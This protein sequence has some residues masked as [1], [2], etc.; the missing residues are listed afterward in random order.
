MVCELM[1][2]NEWSLMMTRRIKNVPLPDSQSSAFDVILCFS[3]HV[4]MVEP[5][6]MHVY[7]ASYRAVPCCGDRYSRDVHTHHQRRR[8]YLVVWLCV[9]CL[10]C[11][12]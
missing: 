7:L 4:D 8:T 5:E 6:V 1:S 9:V 2:V 3:L 10:V 12:K 11:S